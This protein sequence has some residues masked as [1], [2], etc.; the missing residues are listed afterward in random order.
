MGLK[1]LGMG[2]PV[3]G[4]PHTYAFL[5]QGGSGS[6]FRILQLTLDV[7]RLSP[8]SG[9]RLVYAIAA[10]SLKTR[11][12]PSRHFRDVRVSGHTTDRGWPCMT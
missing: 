2:G 4:M 6:K 7:T 9:S 11:R 3:L 1:G 10:W 12:A 8:K 5:I